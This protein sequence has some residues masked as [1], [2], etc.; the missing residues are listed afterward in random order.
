MS[1]LA[2]GFLRRA[3]V[4]SAAIVGLSALLL[5]QAPTT[6]DPTGTLPTDETPNTQSGAVTPQAGRV[7]TAEELQQLLD[8]G[9][10]PQSS[11]V[12]LGIVPGP[13]GTPG[14]MGIPGPDGLPGIPGP[15]GPP[16]PQGPPGPIAPWSAPMVGEVRMWAGRTDSP[17]PGWL[18]CD[19]ADLPRDAFP[20][21]F[22]VIGTSF[23]SGDGV[24]TF[25]LPQSRDRSPMGAAFVDTTT[26][27]SV[28]NVSGSGTLYGGSA[29]HT[30][31]LAE[32]PMHDHDMTHTHD[33]PAGFISAGSG[34]LDQGG[35]LSP[36]SITTGPP[37][38]TMTGS[39]GSGLPHPIL[40]PYFAITFIIY[41]GP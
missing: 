18:V 20:A 22:S 26:G 33:L 25:T 29:L 12:F 19:G 32:M 28:T 35:M 7:L 24:T 34:T 23:G 9:L 1:R 37:S 39:A 15:M 11:I 13:E 17:P 31:S 2:R 5:A 10:N 21:L 41:A 16:G 40:D 38:N 30:L 8:N 14:P 6:C 36:V 3:Q 27:E 4:Q